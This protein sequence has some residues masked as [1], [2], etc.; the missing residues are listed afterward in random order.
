MEESLSR[1]KRLLDK[2]EAMA[3]S[4]QLIPAAQNIIEILS[5]PAVREEY[6]NA[7]KYGQ[8]CVSKSQNPEASL[9]DIIMT[10]DA[11]PETFDQIAEELY[12]AYYIF[13]AP[14]HGTAS[15]WSHLFKDILKSHILISNGT[16]TPPEASAWNGRRTRG[17]L[18][19]QCRLR[20]VPEKSSCCNRTAYC[21]EVCERGA[22]TLRCP[23]VAG[24]ARD[25]GCGIYVISF[26]S[27][28]GCFCDG[29][30]TP[31]KTRKL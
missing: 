11:T 20:L 6:A 23:K 8:H 7:Q 16:T 5:R 27:D 9:D 25:S 1:C 4:L 13:K 2:I 28:W 26:Q 10:G 15:S 18:R 12:D 31:S 24:G 22:M 29:D 17:T 21:W 3:P 19:Q 14:H 30:E